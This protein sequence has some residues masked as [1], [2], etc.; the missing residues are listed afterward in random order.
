MNTRYPSSKFPWTRKA[1]LVAS[2]CFPK[3]SQRL[4]DR[5]IAR[6]WG[7]SVILEKNTNMYDG[8]R[9][10]RRKGAE[11]T[12]LRLDV[13]ISGGEGV[14]SFFGYSVSE[15]DDLEGLGGREMVVSVYMYA[16]LW[17]QL[18][19]LGFNK[20]NQSTII[21]IFLCTILE[22]VHFYLIFSFFLPPII[23]KRKENKRACRDPV[24]FFSDF[25]RLWTRF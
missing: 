13:Q 2:S 22:N 23:R 3:Y 12:Y 16:L 20:S 7:F 24:P 19:A 11:N 18:S 1:V 9:W 25:V 4:I 10:V 5:Y 15:E 6:G 17:P 14:I 8:S 21:P